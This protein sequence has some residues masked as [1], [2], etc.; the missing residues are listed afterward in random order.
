MTTDETDNITEKGEQPRVYIASLSDYNA[1]QHIGRWFELAEYTG[2]DDLL[3]AVTAMLA[4][5]DSHFPLPFG[6]KREEWICLD[7]EHLPNKLVNESPDFNAIYNYLETI[8]D[9]DDERKEAYEL[10]IDNGNDSETFDELYQGKYGDRPYDDD[11]TAKEYAETTFWEQHSEKD[12]PASVR[13]YI[14][15]GS[16]A[17][18]LVLGGDIWVS[19]GH[20]FL[21]R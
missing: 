9:M 16:M 7:A 12:I 15:F 14:D 20:I 5:H 13:N 17:N 19:A 18:D 11:Y 8:E 2:K 21:N 6:Q 3:H 10:F 4:I 1:N